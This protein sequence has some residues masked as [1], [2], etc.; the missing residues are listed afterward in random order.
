V[1]L[2]SYVLP[3][4]VIANSQ[5]TLATLPRPRR[6]QLVPSPVPDSVEAPPTRPRKD[7]DDLSVGVIGRVASWKGQHVF[8][9]AFA[10]AFRGTAA[11]G[12]IIGSPLF[13]EEGYLDSLRQ[14]ADSLGVSAQI[15]FR[16]FRE[17]VWAE[18]SE[19]DVVVH[20]SVIPE[21][22]GQ[23]VLEGMAAGVP[24][25]AAGAG[26]PAEIVTSGVDGILTA[27]GDAHEL[28]AV[29]RRLHDEPDLRARLA[30]GGR[31]RS[32]DF[33]PERTAGRVLDVY[34]ELTRG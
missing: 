1:R 17:D 7:V 28:A 34:S 32:R 11:R 23:V 2:A 33:T 21:P 25:V 14:Q 22:F 10:R 15:E 9:D 26:G 24:V 12:R 16:G 4:A 18:L 13:G 5:T 8:L 30:Q 31:R 6:S 29:L 27:P 20:C 19:L 3:K